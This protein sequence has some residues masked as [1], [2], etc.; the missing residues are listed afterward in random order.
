MRNELRYAWLCCLIALILGIVNGGCKRNDPVA[1]LQLKQGE[2]LGA[3]LKASQIWKGV[4]VGASFYLGDALRTKHAAEAL[5]DLDDNSKLRVRQDTTIRFASTR[6]PKGSHAF[7]VDTGEVLLEAGADGLVL[8]TSIGVARLEAHGQVIIRR[9]ENGVQFNVTVGRAQFES[10]QGTEIVE[11]GKSYFVNVG[12]AVLESGTQDAGKPEPSAVPSS[13]GSALPSAETQLGLEA[14]VTGNGVT[15]RLSGTRAFQALPPGTVRIPLGTTLRVARGSA[16][17]TVRGGAKMSMTGAGTYLVGGGDAPIEVQQGK[18]AVAGATRIVVPGGTIETAND[19]AASVESLNKGRTLVRVG[20]GSATVISKKGTT[21]VSAGQEA[22]LGSD[23]AMK[24]AGKS[25]DYADISAEVGESFMIHDPKPPTAIRFHFGSRCP[26][27]GVIRVRGRAGAMFATGEHSAALA[28]GKG[29]HEYALHC[30]ND[31]G[32][33]DAAVAG[34]TLTVLRDAGT[35]PVPTT[36]PSTSVTVDG[37]SYTV[38]YQNQLPRVSVVWSN[39]PEGATYTLKV[40][41]RHGTKTFMS[42]SPS[43]TFASGALP[44]GRHTVSF[45]GGGKFSRQT[46]IEIVFDNAAP[47]AT[48]TTPTEA[49]LGQDG[50][51]TIAGVAQP[52]W[53]VEVGGQKIAQDAKQRF[54]QGIKLQA[55]TDHAVGIRLTHPTRG[56][57]VYVRRMARGH[58]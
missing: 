14:T 39:A 26:S 3:T 28:L 31:G 50:E 44:E 20:R 13:D 17:Q 38:M 54:N 2:V 48:L 19:A 47:M 49:K 41:S 33:S 24:L 32:Q 22:T 16:V 27:G 25:L 6:P 23:G 12:S 35:R 53:T 51:I 1:V 9:A 56:T 15:Q 7:D 36:P 4:A 10:Q 42:T 11:A 40:V 8:S 55:T 37:R 52:G 43:H 57:H 46:D 34:G 21:S 58:D 45:E 18:L 5:L 29:R 30:L